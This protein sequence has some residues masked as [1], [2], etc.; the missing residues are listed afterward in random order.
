MVP[1]EVG[2]Q[3]LGEDQLAVGQLPQQEVRDAELA[4]RPH[5]QIGIGHVGE[6]E[7]AG[8]G[9]LG[10]VV[11]PA[12]LGHERTDRIDDLGPAA[13]VERERSA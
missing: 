11:R 8:D 3:H 12:P 7:V 9:L 1:A 5:H 13:V 6:V 4:R 2:P 10:D